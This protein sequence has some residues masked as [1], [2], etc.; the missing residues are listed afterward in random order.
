MSPRRWLT[1]GV[2]TRDRPVELAGLLEL[3]VAE[4]ASLRAGWC[5]QVVV[6]D[7]S[8]R[9]AHL[10]DDLPPAVDEVRVVPV[11]GGVSSGRN[12]VAE[13]ARGDVLLLVDDDVRPHPGAL[14]RLADAVEPGTVVAGS[15]R[16]LGHRPHEPS[17]LMAVARTGYGVPAA[18]GAAPDYAVSALLGLPRDVY[19]RVAWDERF[20]AAHLDDVMFGLRLR[21]AGVR[22]VECPAAT[23]DHPPREDNDRPDLAAQRA[24]VVLTR[25]RDDRPVGAW[26]RCLA[27][28]AWSHRS[29]PRDVVTAVGAYLSGTRRWAAAR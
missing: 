23:A 13:H 5:V 29:R 1:V 10:P 9:P 11:Q 2:P 15:V 17:R 21:E 6:A 25:W 26:L 16:G 12:V 8:A 22:L 28:V 7:G 27:H 20:T 4:A 14:A 3:L 19:A 24:L 18:A